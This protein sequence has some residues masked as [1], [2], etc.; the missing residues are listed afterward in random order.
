MTHVYGRNSV[1]HKEEA[2]KL[3][4]EGARMS[5]VHKVSGHYRPP[6]EQQGPSRWNVVRG[7]KV[8]RQVAVQAAESSS[9]DSVLLA[10]E[11]RKRK[12]QGPL[13]LHDPEPD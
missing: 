6:E 5:V 13:E 11:R 2:D 9:K 1:P 4:K 12:R 10:R 8:K 7:C 3:A